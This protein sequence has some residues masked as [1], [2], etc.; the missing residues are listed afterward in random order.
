MAGPSDIVIA[1]A[2]TDVEY[3]AAEK[4]IRD[5]VSWLGIDLSYQDIEAELSDFPKKYLPPRG[6]VL[7]ARMDDHI[8]G[9]VC[10]QALEG[11]I[12]EMKRMWTAPGFRGSGLGRRLA[13]AIVEAARAR[14]YRLMRLDT[15]T[16][17][18][19]AVALY[20]S[21]GFRR[22]P[23]YYHNPTEDVI[24]MELDLTKDAAA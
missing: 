1:P 18:K 16:R 24:Y 12:C 9:T 4:L 17:L 7:L 22:I 21:M 5:Y 19:S 3:R 6:E 2:R 10:L 14:G 13:S 15:L 8:A 20:E 11:D 23:P